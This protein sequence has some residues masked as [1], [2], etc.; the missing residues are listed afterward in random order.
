MVKIGELRKALLN[1]YLNVDKL[2]PTCNFLGETLLLKLFN[3]I[4]LFTYFTERCFIFITI[5]Q[6]F[7]Y[8]DL[9]PKIT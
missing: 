6:E 4:F 9:S 2:N 3:N 5:F 8:Y 1:K 7:L